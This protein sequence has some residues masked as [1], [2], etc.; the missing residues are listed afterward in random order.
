MTQAL[1]VLSAWVIAGATVV[2]TVNII[3]ARAKPATASR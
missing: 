1:I 2:I 3:R